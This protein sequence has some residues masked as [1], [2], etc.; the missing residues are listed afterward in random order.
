MS[1]VQWIESIAH[2]S[3][4][5][6]CEE[7][8]K[9]IKREKVVLNVSAFLVLQVKFEKKEEEEE[10]EEEEEEKRRRRRR[11]NKANGDKQ[12]RWKE[13]ENEFE[14]K[15]QPNHGNGFGL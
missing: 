12:K 7:L 8:V 4:S 2:N 3:V 14:K 10:A 13:A 6:V 11:W 15:T 9:K 5:D 1:W